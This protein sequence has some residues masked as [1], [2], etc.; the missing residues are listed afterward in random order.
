MVPRNASPRSGFSLLELIVALTVLVIG[1]GGTLGMLVANR[2]LGR[3]NR[4]AAIAAEAAESL[5]ERLKAAEFDVV[6][7][8]YNDDPSDDPAG[9]VG[10]GSSFEVPELAPQRDDPD[11]R[12]G[13]ILFPTVGGA[14]REDVQDPFLGMPR[15]LDMDGEI[16]G[17]DHSAD[18]RILPVR[19]RIDWRGAD[20][21]RSI[22]LPLELHR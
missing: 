13:A 8:L 10:P 12:A 16:D 11:G 6:F 19:V 20:G 15:D 1:V 5:L 9:Q 18:Y 4:E 7:A 3:S 17:D 21:D 22:E 2:K 14:L